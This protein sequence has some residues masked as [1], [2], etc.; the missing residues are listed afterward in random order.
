MS[1]IFVIGATGGIGKRL[2]PMLVAAGHSV[3]GLARDSGHK[4]WYE[5]N[6]VT[7]VEGDL[8][9]I[10]VESLTEL[11][12]DADVIVFSAGAA[13]SGKERTTLIDGE[14]PLKVIGAMRRNQIKR[15]YLVSVFPEAGRT[16]ELGEGFEHYMSVKK[17]ADV[18]IVE[19][20][21]DW[22]I[23]RPGTLLNEEGDGS[24]SLAKAL[25]YSSVK[26]GNV[27]KV[28]ATLIEAPH[29]KRDIFEL[30][31][32]DHAVDKAVAALA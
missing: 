18:A 11:T 14:G 22:V 12:K 24:V 26:R 30:T 2:C 7:M 21:L 31:D 9:D 16:K 8:M 20:E 4:D 1:N 3:S 17:E 25:P 19:S 28:L 6:Q 5:Q 23:L 32:G 13:G 29:I 15:L 10:T 27:A